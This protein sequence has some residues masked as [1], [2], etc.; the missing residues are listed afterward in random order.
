MADGATA[1]MGLVGNEGVVGIALFMGGE[2]TPKQA[3]AQVAGGALRMTAQTLLEEF[4]RGGPLASLADQV[5]HKHCIVAAIRPDVERS[6]P[7]PHGS[8]DHGRDPRFPQAIE[9]E[10]GRY[11]DV[12]RV[13]EELVAEHRPGERRALAKIDGLA[14][15]ARRRRRSRARPSLSGAIAQSLAERL[16]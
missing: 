5:G 2:T 9:Q 16:E 11:T 6:H 1:E 10:M 12:A 14:A 13:D 15:A 7:G 3:V 8:P 4:R